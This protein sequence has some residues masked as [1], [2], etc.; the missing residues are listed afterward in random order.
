MNDG[1][2]FQQGE[3]VVNGLLASVSG[4]VAF[5]IAE[6]WFISIALPVIF[7]IVG[8]AVDVAVKLYFARKYPEYVRKMLD[9]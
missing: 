5:V 7:F 2:L 6:N 4:A 3:N 8:K 9:K 1:R